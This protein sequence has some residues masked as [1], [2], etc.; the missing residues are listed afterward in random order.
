[1]LSYVCTY[2]QLHYRFLFYVEFVLT[3]SREGGQL[4]GSFSCQ[5][6]ESAIQPLYLFFKRKIRFHD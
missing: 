1:M 3:L 2:F 6:H 5:I 4:V